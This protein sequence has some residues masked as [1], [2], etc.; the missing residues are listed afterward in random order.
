[1]DAEFQRGEA[2]IACGAKESALPFSV[3]PPGKSRGGRVPPTPKARRMPAKNAGTQRCCRL[4]PQEGYAP[5]CI[6]RLCMEFIESRQAL[7]PGDLG[8]FYFAG[9]RNFLFCVD[10]ES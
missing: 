3:S 4:P 10:T 9:N 5:L 7:T 6:P 2:E 1:M 8:T